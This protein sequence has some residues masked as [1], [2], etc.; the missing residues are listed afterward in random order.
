MSALRSLHEAIIVFRKFEEKAMSSQAEGLLKL[1]YGHGVY[2]GFSA[3]RDTTA[4][5]LIRSFLDRVS[6]N[7]QRSFSQFEIRIYR[8]GV[9]KP[10][11]NSDY[12]LRIQQRK[13]K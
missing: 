8:K 6:E 2:K 13:G 4:G 3:K 11:E 12:P 5:E 1:Y 7:N 10:I 9:S